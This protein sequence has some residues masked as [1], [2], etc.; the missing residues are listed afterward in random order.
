MKFSELEIGERFLITSNRPGYQKVLTYF[1]QRH[2][3]RVNVAFV[4]AHIETLVRKT[5]LG[6]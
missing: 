3:D 1:K 2:D 6:F 5:L 4:D